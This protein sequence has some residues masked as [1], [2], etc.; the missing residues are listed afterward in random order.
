MAAVVASAAPPTPIPKPP[1]EGQV[2]H[3]V[4]NAADHQHP[5]RSAAVAQPAQDPGIEIIPHI[6]QAS[7]RGDAQIEHGVVP[8]IGG[9][10]HQ[11][12]KQRSQHQSRHSQRQ[13]S[14]IKQPDGRAGQFL[15]AV[16]IAPARC[17]GYQDGNPRPD[18]QKYAEQDFQGLGA[19]GHR[20]QGRGITEIA[21]N[22]R[23]HGAVELLQHIAGT[24]RQ[25][26][27]DGGGQNGALRHIDT[28]R[29]T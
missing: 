25:G 12:Q 14:G 1:H 6:A 10:L 29:G 16:G 11:A 23:V 21:D 5:Q 27:P 3:D 8:G 19:G 13:G 20:R 24:D 22:Q 17:L 7:Q 28:G 15:L 18:A 4:D 2:S 9:H 26:K